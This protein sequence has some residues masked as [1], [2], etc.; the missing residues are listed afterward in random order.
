[1]TY[2]IRNIYTGA[3]CENTTFHDRDEA[4]RFYK[5]QYHREWLDAHEVAVKD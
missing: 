5:A 1:M 2:G 4:V 3:W